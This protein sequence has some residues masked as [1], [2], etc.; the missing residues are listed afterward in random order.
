MK[1]TKEQRQN[2][3]RNHLGDAS[4]A[5]VKLMNALAEA[6][7]MRRGRSRHMLDRL[8]RDAEWI[9]RQVSNQIDALEPKGGPF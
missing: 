4:A 7:N 5:A 3:L 6:H 8:W 1:T 2:V 9:Q